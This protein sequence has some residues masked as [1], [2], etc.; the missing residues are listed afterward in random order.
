MEWWRISFLLWGSLGFSFLGFDLSG[1]LFNWGGVTVSSFSLLDVLWEDLVVLGSL[2]LGSL[3]S[4]DLLSL[5]ELLSSESLLGDESLD[6]W[7]L[8]E[9]LVS[10]LDFSSDN[11]LSNIVLL[12]EGEDLSNVVGSLGA[13]SSWLV[14]VSNTFDLLIALLDDF[15][16]DD[17]KIW[18]ADAASD[19]LSLSLTGSSW[20][21]SWSLY[22]KYN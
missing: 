2:L 21:V 12:S 10:L 4:V 13:E 11:V 18:T 9:S 17:G 15:E 8:V 3:E 1:G 19:W 7:W 16:L 20:S 22:F 5:D 14:T 6:L